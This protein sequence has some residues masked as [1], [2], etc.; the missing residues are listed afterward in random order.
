MDT[1]ELCEQLKKFIEWQIECL[2]GE[3]HPKL[4]HMWSETEDR[5]IQL[6]ELLPPKEDG[7]EIVFTLRMPHKLYSDLLHCT[8]Y[9]KK[10]VQSFV[11]ECI[12]YYV[13]HH[14]TKREKKYE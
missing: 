10:P 12:E 3:L 9:T 2:E 7:E 11:L 13:Q 6:F 1:H 14:F 5:W 4:D 8:G